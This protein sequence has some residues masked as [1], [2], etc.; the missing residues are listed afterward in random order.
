[1]CVSSLLLFPRFAP[2][3]SVLAASSHI[4]LAIISAGK[5]RLF[6]AGVGGRAYPVSCDGRSSIVGSSCRGNCSLGGELSIGT[7]LD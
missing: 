1:M 2:P 5:V 4:P 3:P 6:G 7:V